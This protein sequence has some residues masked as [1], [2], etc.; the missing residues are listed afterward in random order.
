MA[1]LASK[2]DDKKDEK[3][4]EKKDKKKEEPQVIH[5]AASEIVEKPSTSFIGKT[6]VIEADIASDDDVT[7]E[8]KVTGNIV[9]GKT[10]TIGKNGSVKADIK[11]G[12][13][14]IIGEARGNI[15]ASEKV[16]ILTLGRYTGN[17][18]S[19]KLIVADGAL[20]NGEINQENGGKTKNRN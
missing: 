2:K 6:M 18:Q 19:Q 3:K 4:D 12:V 17:I 10:L 5:S 13:V 15:I 8:G 1:F 9:V 14:R 20:L 11:A 7:I 16:E